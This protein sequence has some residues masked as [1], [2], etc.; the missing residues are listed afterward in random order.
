VQLRAVTITINGKPE[1]FVL[2][3]EILPERKEC[4]RRAARL[5]A[6]ARASLQ[7]ET[8]L[9]LAS[10][11]HVDD[12]NLAAGLPD[13]ERF[14]FDEAIPQGGD[15]IDDFGLHCDFSFSPTGPEGGGFD[16]SDG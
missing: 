6:P 11:I 16:A 14:R 4:L 8:L 1:R 13:L 15:L 7:K 10:P 9:G 3:K 2:D 5:R 12:C